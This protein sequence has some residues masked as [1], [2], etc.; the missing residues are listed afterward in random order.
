MEQRLC[1]E[2]EVEISRSILCE[3]VNGEWGRKHRVLLLSH[4][5][6]HRDLL[7]FHLSCFFPKSI[8]FRSFKVVGSQA[9]NKTSTCKQRKRWFS[10]A[11]VYVVH[12]WPF[13]KQQITCHEVPN[14]KQPARSVATIS[15][16]IY[17]IICG[18]RFNEWEDIK[19][20]GKL[21]VGSY[22]EKERAWRS[23]VCGTR[24]SFV[25]KLEINTFFTLLHL[26]ALLL[27]SNNIHFFTLNKHV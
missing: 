24:H 17:C 14:F 16:N 6:E 22:S 19:L 23:Q 12:N 8:C 4:F 25:S 26:T 13:P 27:W 11:G 20:Y 9:L 5:H 15:R 2:S 7:P 1:W 18:F 3:T 10:A 21:S